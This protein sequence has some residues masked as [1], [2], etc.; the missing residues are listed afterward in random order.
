MGDKTGT[1]RPVFEAV[2]DTFND[3][4]GAV[5]KLMSANASKILITSDHGFLFQ[6]RKIDESDYA[7]AGVTGEDVAFVNRRYALGRGLEP[8]A[9]VT[10]FT[11][12]AVG[13]SGDLQIQIPKSIN[14]LRRSGSGARF[15]HGGASLQ[16]VVIPILTVTKSRESDVEAVEVE[17]LVGD[18]RVIT[19]SQLGVRLY[20]S[21][22]VN[23]KLQSRELKVGI[24]SLDG[25]LLSDEQTLVFDSTSVD[26]RDR[27]RS[28]RLLLNRKADDFNNQEVVLKL[29][30]RHKNTS[31]FKDYRT[32]RYT[33]RRRQT[34]FD[35]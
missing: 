17:I 32:V 27:E 34:D 4:E 22:P 8:S 3:L 9:S 23:D 16:E 19:T 24:Y 29:S 18:S 2:E 25:D 12:S 33:L 35:F 14:R 7:S 11:S 30:E 15:V 20:Q 31:A 26:T 10:T 5:R 6:A 21:E 1:E 13:L 28:I